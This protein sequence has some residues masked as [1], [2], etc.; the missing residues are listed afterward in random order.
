MSKE[1]GSASLSI[2][3][4]KTVLHGGVACVCLTLKLV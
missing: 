4:N 1:Q 3:K 2:N